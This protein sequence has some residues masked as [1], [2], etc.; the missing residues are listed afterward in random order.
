MLITPVPWIRTLPAQLPSHYMGVLS[1]P[2]WWFFGK[3]PFMGRKPLG[4]TP[5]GK[6]HTWPPWPAQRTNRP[7]TQ[8]AGQEKTEQKIASM[9]CP[10]HPLP[11]N[12]AYRPSKTF[13][14][15]IWAWV[16]GRCSGQCYQERQVCLVAMEKLTSIALEVLSSDAQTLAMILRLLR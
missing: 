5:S 14:R 7:E 4:L 10:A 2:T 12:S 1:L 15:E 11:C 16:A 3:A 13:Y 9:A 6:V 8:H